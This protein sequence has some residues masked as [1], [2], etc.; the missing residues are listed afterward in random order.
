MEMEMKMEMGY[1]A[2][3]MKPHLSAYN[4]NVRTRA[5][6]LTNP[7]ASISNATMFLINT[8]TK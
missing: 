6:K 4:G 5:L 1:S 2:F 3:K 7:F 8:S